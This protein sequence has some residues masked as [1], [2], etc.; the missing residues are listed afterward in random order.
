MITLGI[1]GVVA[2]LTIS[3][4][5]AKYQQK[6]LNTQFKKSYALINQALLNTLS[7]YGYIPGCYYP[8]TSTSGN[9]LEYD[10]NDFSEKFIGSLKVSKMCE[11]N[12]YADGCIPEYE[13]MDTVANANNPDAEVPE[14]YE[15]YGD[16][17]SS[18]CTYFRKNAILNDR[19]VYVLSD[20]TIIIPY[21]QI[22]KLIA[23][24]I[25]GQKGP[26]KWGYD[27]FS[28]ILKFDGSKL[29]YDG[30]GCMNPEKGGVKTNIMIQRLHKNQL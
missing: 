27:L 29:Y 4:L 7:Q 23:V 18:G 2:A 11:G 22:V 6:A 3:T 1:I 24:D 15:N 20:G 21:G 13:G 5:V 8:A 10:C 26:N 9:E 28:F 30:G 14:G 12:A 19:T 25:N 16:Y 17:I